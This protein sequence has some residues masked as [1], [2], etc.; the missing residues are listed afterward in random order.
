MKE[1]SVREIRAALPRLEEI[2]EQE[3]ELVVTRN[4]RAVARLLPPR[5]SVM[6]PSHADFRARQK[7]LATTSEELVRQ[8]RDDR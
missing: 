2:L 8:D 1:L 3:G 5:A 4:G 7:R 6:L